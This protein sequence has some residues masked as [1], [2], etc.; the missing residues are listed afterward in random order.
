MEATFAY[1]AV[2]LVILVL[3]ACGWYWY[4]RQRGEDSGH[5]ATAWQVGE[6]LVKCPW[7]NMDYELLKEIALRNLFWY[8][9]AKAT[10]KELDQ[11]VGVGA[12]LSYQDFVDMKNLWSEDSNDPKSKI[13]VVVRNTINFSNSEI[14]KRE[15]N[16]YFK[17][18]QYTFAKHGTAIRKYRVIDNDL[19]K[20]FKQERYHLVAMCNF[21]LSYGD[22]FHTTELN[23]MYNKIKNLWLVSWNNMEYEDPY[24]KERLG[25]LIDAIRNTPYETMWAWYDEARRCTFKDL[26]VQIDMVKAA[27]ANGWT[28]NDNPRNIR[29]IFTQ[30]MFIQHVRKKNVFDDVYKFWHITRSVHKLYDTLILAMSVYLQNRF[31]YLLLERKQAIK[32]LHTLVTGKLED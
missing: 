1:G 22:V 28:A 6:E 23:L 13:N 21:P 26:E 17:Y 27:V 3:I 31:Q 29:D 12:A 20:C 15:L 32:D 18:I 16:S 11:L 10:N 2:G 5:T 4:K 24:N 7:K 8:N 19:H 30:A 25:A 9:Y 14:S